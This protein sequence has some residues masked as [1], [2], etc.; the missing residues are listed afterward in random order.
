[1]RAKEHFDMQLIMR[2]D[3]GIAIKT[4]AILTQSF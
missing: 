4:I 1:M 2:V 3:F